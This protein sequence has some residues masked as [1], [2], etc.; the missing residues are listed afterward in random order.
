RRRSMWRGGG[1]GGPGAARE[2]APDAAGAPVRRGAPLDAPARLGEGPTRSR[3][4]DIP[5]PAAEPVQPA[6]RRGRP[7]QGLAGAPPRRGGAEAASWL[8]RGPTRSVCR[9]P[10]GT[11]S[12]SRP[13]PS[14]LDSPA[15]GPPRRTRAPSCGSRSVRGSTTWPHMASRPLLLMTRERLDLRGVKCPLSWAHARIRLEAM[16]TGDELELLLDDAQAATDIPRAAEASGHHV[17]AVVPEPPLWRVVLE[18]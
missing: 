12:A 13:A 7:R 11:A 9:G 16:P 8:I 4:P 18:V 14:C 1:D 2:G 3:P 6:G 5:A 10:S 17:V 15:S